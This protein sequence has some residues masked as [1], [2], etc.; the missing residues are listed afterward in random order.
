M[1][2]IVIVIVIVI[3]GHFPKRF[4]FITLT[5]S[6][7][8]RERDSTFFT[9]LN[10]H[11]TLCSRFFC[12][13]PPPNAIMADYSHSVFSVLAEEELEGARAS[14]FRTVSLARELRVQGRLKKRA[15]EA[16]SWVLEDLERRR[17]PGHHSYTI[18]DSRRIRSALAELEDDLGYFA[19][20]GNGRKK[21][22]GKGKLASALK[23]KA[24]GTKRSAKS[25]SSSS[26]AQVGVI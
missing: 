9:P 10:R 22:K 17:S 7:M 13:V 18:A 19:A 11:F 23:V 15:A 3:I 12:S 2:I 4:L 16:E 24:T 25:T 5:Y 20:E 8:S 21:S 26:T 6:Y 1:R 14:A